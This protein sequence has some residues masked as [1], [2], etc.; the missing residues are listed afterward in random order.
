[1]VVS[2]F[3]KPSVSATNCLILKSY[4]FFEGIQPYDFKSVMYIA[5]YLTNSSYQVRGQSL[6]SARAR[7]TSNRLK[8]IPEQ[9]PE[10][11]T[12]PGVTLGNLSGSTVT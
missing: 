11:V 9:L 12:V 10:P 2:S 3:S 4:F 7:L 6:A 5:G 1:V 8:Q